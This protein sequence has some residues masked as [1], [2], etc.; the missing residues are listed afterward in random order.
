M[1]GNSTSY[2]NE[3]LHGAGGDNPLDPNGS[4]YGPPNKKLIY[5]ETAPYTVMNICIELE[6][7]ISV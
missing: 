1:W 6:G 5:E 4:I 2:G 7:N 3:S